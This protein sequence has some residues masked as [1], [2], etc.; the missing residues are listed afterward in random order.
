MVSK[1]FA[2]A[3]TEAA[4]STSPLVVAAI[5]MVARIDLPIDTGDR[6]TWNGRGIAPKK[7]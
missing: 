1:V 5:F 7:D 4:L 2:G 3:F 6:Q